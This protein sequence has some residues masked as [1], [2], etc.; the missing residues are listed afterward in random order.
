MDMQDRELDDVFRS[1]LEGFEAEPTERVWTGIYTGLDNEKRRRIFIPL[2]IAAGV[3]ILLT[4]G[5]L[6]VM[7]K[8]NNKPVKHEQNSLAQNPAQ[9]VK[10]PDVAVPAKQTGQIKPVV[11]QAERI[12][13]V[14][15]HKKVAKPVAVNTASVV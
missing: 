12:A 13:R 8:E 5:L 10:K 4:A 14:V 9:T 2:R 6:L 3:I 15:T 1:K 11:H 7:H